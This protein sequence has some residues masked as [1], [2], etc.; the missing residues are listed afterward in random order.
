VQVNVSIRRRLNARDVS[1][2]AIVTG[3][4]ASDYQ[5][6]RLTVTPANVTLQGSID[7]L[8]EVG[9]VVNTLPVDVSLATHD[10]TMQVPL[11]LPP[12][13]QAMDNSGQ[14]AR[15]VMVSVE[16]TARSGN[17]AVSRP[18]KLLK[19]TPNI[20]VTID[21][22]QVDLLLSG[23]LPILNEVEADPDLIQVLLDVTHLRSGR[24][25][26]LIPEVIT[27]VELEAQ[28]IPPSVL[29]VVE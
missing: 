18:I 24:T 20:T 5:L 8:A 13:V 6:S 1:V 2:Q 22:P 29:V 25:A 3:N 10:L 19:T 21:P 9:N 11:D 27:P 16:I 17:L 23:P 14:P 7:Q 26:N 15:I 28:V 4:P 12:N